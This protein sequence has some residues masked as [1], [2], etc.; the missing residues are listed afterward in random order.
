MINIFSAAVSCSPDAYR[1]P[2]TGFLSG[3]TGKLGRAW[4]GA[5]H[6]VV[7]KLGHNYF[8]LPAFKKISHAKQI[9]LLK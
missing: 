3:M 8:I 1:L 5:W 4:V 2:A 7:G 9:M 6:L